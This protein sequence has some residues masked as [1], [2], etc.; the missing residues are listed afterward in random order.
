MRRWKRKRNW[1]STWMPRQLALKREKKLALLKG[2]NATVNP[3]GDVKVKKTLDNNIQIKGIK[4]STSRPKIKIS[5][6]KLD[7]KLG[8]W[9]AL[10]QSFSPKYLT[11]PIQTLDNRNRE[12]RLHLCNICT[13]WLFLLVSASSFSVLSSLS[14]CTIP[15]NEIIGVEQPRRQASRHLLC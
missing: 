8:K 4:P 1:M 12:L 5:M 2:S 6:K 10:A 11:E 14:C 3:E 13:T 15:R 9:S 7:K